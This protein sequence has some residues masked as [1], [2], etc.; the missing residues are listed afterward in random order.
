MHYRKIDAR[1]GSV[2]PMPI[3]TNESD[4]EAEEIEISIFLFFHWR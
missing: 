4:E 1:P 3:E 2:Q